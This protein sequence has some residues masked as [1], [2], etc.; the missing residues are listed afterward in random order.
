MSKKLVAYFSVSGATAA[1]AKTLAEVAGAELYEI[2]PEIPYTR[3]DLNWTDPYARSTKEMKGK[4]PYPP[5]ADKAA[6]IA[7]CDVIFLGFPISG[8]KIILFATSGG[9]AFGK[10]AAEL[11]K[12]LPDNAELLEG[13]MMNG[14]PSE[15]E[16]TNWVQGLKL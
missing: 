5:I 10:T 7:D 9:S 14:S 15:A 4:L 1:V 16:L 12:S 11:K 13:R 8:K 2:E 6:P 3:A